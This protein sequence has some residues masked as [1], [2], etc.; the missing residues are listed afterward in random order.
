MTE[1]S[2][3]MA[4]MM[5]CVEY[6]EIGGISPELQLPGSGGI[7]LAMTLTATALGRI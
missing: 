4:T 2:T 6:S 1:Y 3:S 5:S 7:R